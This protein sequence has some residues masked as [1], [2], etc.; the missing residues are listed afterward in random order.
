MSL[1]HELQQRLDTYVRQQDTYTYQGNELASQTLVGLIA[2]T[3]AGKSTL[4]SHIL[5]EGSKQGLSVGE[6]GTLTTRKR[7]PGD[8]ENYRTDIPHEEMLSLIEKQALVSWSLNPTGHI[9]ATAPESFAATHNFLPL[10]PDSLPVLR[11]A[12][13]QAVHA[14]YITAPLEQ[15]RTQLAERQGDTDFTDRLREAKA[16]LEQ[17]VLHENDWTILENRQGEAN[18]R[19]L[20]RQI[21]QCVAHGNTLTSSAAALKQRDEM[22]AY[23]QEQL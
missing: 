6:V 11:R 15:W 1:S 18:L 22:L 16:S 21:L 17:A 23:V 7:R 3:A 10:L 13:F 8:P 20:A 5:D 12:G 9:Y 4:V 14:F 2:P 19:V